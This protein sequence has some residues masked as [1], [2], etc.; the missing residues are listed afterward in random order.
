MN[1]V[2][3]ICGK[4]MGIF[5][6]WCVFR[7]KNEVISKRVIWRRGFD[8]IVCRNLA[9]VKKCFASYRKCRLSSM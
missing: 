6:I 5:I 1:G 8:N 3:V 7:G 2:I 4:D 9:A